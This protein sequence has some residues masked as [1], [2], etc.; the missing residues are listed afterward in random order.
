MKH[1]LI[2]K[3]AALI[4]AAFFI[5]LSCNTSKKTTSE[6]LPPYKPV[7]QVLFNTV[8]SL[9]SAFFDSYNTCKMDVMTSMISE[10]IEFYHDLGGLSTS[11]SNIVQ[12][13]QN[14]ICGKVKREL[15]PGS[16]E[17]YPI[18]G[19]GAVQ[20]GVHRF[21]HLVEKSTSRY[22]RFVSTWHLQNG[23][24]KLSRVISLH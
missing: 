2:K 12:S 21:H 7:S 15:L 10:D 19:Y 6:G 22:A 8:F 13:I 18:P 3:Y 14:N 24:W 5:L 17:V 23:Q 4:F 1:A 9:D 20:F 11:K 16:I